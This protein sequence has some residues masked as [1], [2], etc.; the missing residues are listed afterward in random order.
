MAL[1]CFAM[2]FLH[3]T[4]EQFEAIDNPEN[5]G[6]VTIARSDMLPG[7]CFAESGGWRVQGLRRLPTY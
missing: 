2:R 7:E 5:G 3:L 6:V 1:R 4:V